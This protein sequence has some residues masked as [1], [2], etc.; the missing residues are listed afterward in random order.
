[1]IQMWRPIEW[2][3]LAIQLSVLFLFWTILAAAFA[4]QFYLVDHGGPLTIPWS[5]SF[6]R[7]LSEWYPWIIL[8]PPIIWL[9]NRLRF[10][11]ALWW[12]SLLPHLAACILVAVLYQLLVGWF[13]PAP[14]AVFRGTAPSGAGFAIAG[15]PSVV[16]RPFGTNNLPPIPVGQQF[17]VLVPGASNEWTAPEGDPPP[18]SASP[19]AQ[20]P[21]VTLTPLPVT[22]TSPAVGTALNQPGGLLRR[23]FVTLPSPG[24]PFSGPAPVLSTFTTSWIASMPSPWRTT[25]RLKSTGSSRPPT[26][27]CST[28]V[29]KR[30]SC[31]RRCAV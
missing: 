24:I 14:F 26:T 1:M 2:R 17:R 18:A 29:S 20:F 27:P 23:S 13:G 5:Y 22:L 9:A 4:T 16:L 11:R 10:D 15:N 19:V 28:S 8:S 7:A 31:E 6:Y 12:R 25:L 3:K 21:Q 30:I